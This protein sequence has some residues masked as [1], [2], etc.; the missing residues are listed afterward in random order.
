MDLELK[1]ENEKLTVKIIGKLDTMTSPKLEEELSKKIDGIQEIIFD[2]EELK[3]ISSSGIRVLVST[4]KKIKN[5]KILKPS[6]EVMK[7][8]TIT[9][10]VNVF[11]IEK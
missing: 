2:L 3:Y 7:V 6:D 8:F 4:K 11:N 9:R 10:L 5:M 1:N